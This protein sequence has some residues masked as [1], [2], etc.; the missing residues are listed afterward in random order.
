MF[1]NGY[2]IS[3]FHL[4]AKKKSPS[5]RQA[6]DL[7]NRAQDQTRTD[8][9]LPALPPQSSVSTNFTTCALVLGL[10][11][12]KLFLFFKIFFTNFAK[13]HC[14][15]LHEVKTGI[16]D[17]LEFYYTGRDALN[18]LYG[19]I[20]AAETSVLLEFFIIEDDEIGQ[21]FEKLLCAKSKAGVKVLVCYDAFGSSGTGRKFFRRMADSGVRVSKFNPFFSAYGITHLNHRNHRKLAVI[22]KKVSFV[23]GVNIAD[24]YFTG[25]KYALWRDT[26]CRISGEAT[27]EKL[28]AI[29]YNDFNH[30]YRAG[31]FIGEE[32]LM[33]KLS[34][35]RKSVK[36]LTPYFAPSKELYKVLA[37]A[38]MRGVEIDLMIPYRTDS[39]ILHYCNMASV[40]HCLGMGMRLHLFYNGFNHS[41]V[42]IVDD[43]IAYVGSAN[44][45][46]RSLR[47]D[48]EIMSEIGNTKYVDLLLKRFFR[49]L[50][51]CQNLE[52]EEDWKE[53]PK[54]SRLYERLARLLY[55]FL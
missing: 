49:D 32:W 6:L 45:D 38:C 39:N 52:S 16:D 34:S 47:L 27:A 3:I 5:I 53:R 7:R 18:A 28:S 55:R 51:Y 20:E 2:K 9:P 33:S 19:T 29:F 22:D 17:A 43:N 21:R 10:Q 13:T 4:R 26:F 50:K 42:L 11:R 36:I 25:G 54:R 37:A 12:Y 48:Y 14:M 41:K 23:G 31:G 46:N 15:R 40:K 1:Y 24:R 30:I 35:A 8:T 44:M